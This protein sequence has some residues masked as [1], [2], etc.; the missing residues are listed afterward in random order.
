MGSFR[1]V[2][3]LCA[4]LLVSVTSCGS[5]N[6]SIDK[7]DLTARLEITALAG[8]VCPVET[9]PPSPDCAPQPVDAANMIVTDAEGTEVGHRGLRHGNSLN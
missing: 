4:L 5:S 9:D 8:P 1:R 6:D 7:S 2:V 3:A